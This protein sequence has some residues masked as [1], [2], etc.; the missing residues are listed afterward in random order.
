MINARQSSGTVTSIVTQSTPQAAISLE[1]QAIGAS[2]VGCVIIP[3]DQTSSC[4]KTF[5]STAVNT[6]SSTV[7]I[8]AHGMATGLV[9]QMTTT[10]S[11]PAGLSTSTN[12]YIIVVDANTIAFASSLA[13]ANAG[14]KIT[15]TTQGSG[16]DTFTPTALAGATA[17]FQVSND[18][19]NWGN[20]QAATS[21][22]SG[23]NAVMYPPI[24]AAPGF[25][26]L[27]ILLT[28]TSGQLSVQTQTVVKG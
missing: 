18:G 26:W 10:G 4:T 6:A 21:L 1:N 22:T 16:N 23:T 12:Y 7:T 15:L 11:L 8:T 9:G 24:G 20:W 14:T 28:V 27:R 13:N 25:L 2:A 19:I 17:V 3:T 5:A